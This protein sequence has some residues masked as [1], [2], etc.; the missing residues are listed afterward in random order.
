MKSF[1][2][3]LLKVVNLKGKD[4]LE[5]YLEAPKYESREIKKIRQNIKLLML[6]FFKYFCAFK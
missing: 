6:K 5:L 4:F 3:T 1:D 2:L